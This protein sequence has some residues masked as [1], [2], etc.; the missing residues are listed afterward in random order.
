MKSKFG[1]IFYEKPMPSL[2]MSGMNITKRRVVLSGI[3]RN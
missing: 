3:K 2:R 1:K